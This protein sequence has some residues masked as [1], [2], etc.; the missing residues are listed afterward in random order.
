[1]SDTR[2]SS[3]WRRFLDRPNTAR[4]KTIGMSLLVA[5]GCG[6][7]GGGGGP[8]TTLADGAI[9]VAT[10]IE[11]S[12]DGEVAV[13]GNL[14][15]DVDAGALVLCEDVASDAD[16]PDVPPT[17]CAGERVEV[18]GVGIDL[19]ALDLGWQSADGTDEYSRVVVAEGTYDG[20]A[21]IVR[22]VEMQG[23]TVVV[24]RSTTT[25]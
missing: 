9:G 7:D 1:M 6:G 17:V 3:L 12:P 13:Q 18:R 10:L 19:A 24:E 14:Y 22:S 23:T 20:S 16:V 11:R 2:L 21:L 15:A 4:V 25:G 8:S 5:V